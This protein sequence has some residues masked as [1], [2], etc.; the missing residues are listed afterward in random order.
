VV[1]R[2]GGIPL[3]WCANPCDKPDV[4]QFPV[5]IEA[6]A[7]WHEAICAAIRPKQPA[8]NR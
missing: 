8:S 3:A 4:T 6:L 2:D 5:M 1:T 7:A